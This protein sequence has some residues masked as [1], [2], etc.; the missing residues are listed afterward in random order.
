MFMSMKTKKLYLH[1][2]KFALGAVPERIQPFLLPGKAVYGI[3]EPE[4]KAERV[5]IR[6]EKHIPKKRK[7]RSA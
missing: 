4:A 5:I 6:Q 1:S 7:E 3:L 2:C